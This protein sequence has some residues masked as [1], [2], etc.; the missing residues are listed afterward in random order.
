MIGGEI[1]KGSGLGL[2][3]VR[4]SRSCAALVR[5][6]EAQIIGKPFANDELAS[7]IKLAFARQ[8]SLS[9]N[10]VDDEST[11]NPAPAPSANV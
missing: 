5:V 1:G 3:Q 10:S 9:P 11:L 4:E 8:P 7:K 6:N 2:S